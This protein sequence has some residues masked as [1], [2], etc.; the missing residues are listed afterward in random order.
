MVLAEAQYAN[1]FAALRAASY[2]AANDPLTD[3]R[4]SGYVETY[5]KPLRITSML[6][7]VIQ[8]S[9]RRLGLLCLEHVDQKHEWH[10]DEIQF[11]CDLADKMAMALLNRSRLDA[12]ARLEVSEA[13]HRSILEASPDLVAISDLS[14]RLTLLSPGAS[15]IL[16]REEAAGFVGQ[17]VVGLI[18]PADRSRA[19]A[20]LAL[21]ASGT[22]TPLDEYLIQLPD[23]RTFEADI[24]GAFIRDSVGR[25]AEAVFFVRDVTER[26]EAREAARRANELLRT[27]VET[28]P[29][30]IFWKDRELRYL[31]CNSAFARDA[32]LSG[33]EDVIGKNDFDLAWRPQAALYRADDEAIM[34]S[35]MPKLDYEE[36]QTTPE[37]QTIWLSTS[38]V[39]LRGEN[40]VVTG[41]LGMYRDVTRR[42]EADEALH[43][44]L[45]EKEALLKEVHH[46]VKNNLQVINSLL[47]LE[48]RRSKEPAVRGALGEM[49]GRVLSM[50]VLHETLYR[51]RTFGRVNLAGYL[52]ELAQQ[53]LR[54]HGSAAASTR[55]TLDLSPVDVRVDQ[56]IPCGLI[57]NE[58]LTN[59]LK[60]A[61]PDGRGGE[62][63]VVLRKVA[64]HEVLLQVSD[65]GPGL[66]ADYESRRPGS[67]GMQL[68][69][70][71]A[72]QIGGR[73]EVGPGPGARFDI[74]FGTGT[75]ERERPTKG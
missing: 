16:R 61:F 74:T 24:S 28:A 37:G 51:T 38:K 7:A 49:Q 10:N 19:A 12:L 54:A 18:A 68:V 69:A 5:L 47:R 55:L 13:R 9:G 63:K 20:A 46:R 43:E 3:P 35:G 32:G 21:I 66:P 60:Y 31:G 41:V 2:V 59:S 57:L 40:N 53:F 58:L 44:S 39:P 45:A 67:L 6:D 52:R 30:R 23:G 62:I 29:A 33:P 73:L 8:F 71:L 50:A 72:R 26:T 14:G 70:D 64:S 4:T 11:A 1:E 42:R 65:T 17:S 75:G 27:V 56:G 25:P 36:P 34:E 15:T 22:M 48:A